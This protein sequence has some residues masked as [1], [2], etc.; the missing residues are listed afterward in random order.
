M[1]YSSNEDDT[2]DGNNY[3]HVDQLRLELTAGGLTKQ[4]QIN[5]MQ[6]IHIAEAGM[7]SGFGFFSRNYP[8]PVWRKSDIQIF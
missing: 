4:Q 6:H 3:I 8:Y 1:F 2:T 5:V 7:V